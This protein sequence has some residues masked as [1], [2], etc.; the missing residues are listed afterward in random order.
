MA[1]TSSEAYAVASASVSWALRDKRRTQRPNATN[2]N[3]TSGIASRTNPESRGR[4]IT[5]IAVAPMNSITLRSA[6]D[7]EPP[8]ADLIWAVSAERGGVSFHVDA[9]EQKA[10]DRDP[11]AD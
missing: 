10:D 4:V 8:T 9:A 3:T 11:A 2:G 1:P 5:I 7:T 6:T